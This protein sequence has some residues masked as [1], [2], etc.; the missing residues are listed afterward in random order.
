M[1]TYPVKGRRITGKERQKLGRKLANRYEQGSSIQ[2]LANLTGRS[3]GFIHRLLLEAG[4][5][6]RS[7]GINQHRKPTTRR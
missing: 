3:Y 5:T 1:T 7:P 6:M 2:Q 4:V